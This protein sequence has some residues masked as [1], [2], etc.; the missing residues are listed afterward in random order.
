MDFMIFLIK[1]LDTIHILLDV[2]IFVQIFIIVCL[3]L[4]IIVC[5]L[6]GYSFFNIMKDKIERLVNLKYLSHFVMLW[7][8][9]LIF[10][11]SIGL[12]ILLPDTE[13]G[14]KI[15]FSQIKNIEMD[16]PLFEDKYNS[17][18]FYLMS[19]YHDN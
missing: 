8:Y 1:K 5:T 4:S 3:I 19:K 12:K 18:R 14:F 10:I 11:T 7:I 16:D 9:M 17:F 2:A 6:K 15:Y 13:N